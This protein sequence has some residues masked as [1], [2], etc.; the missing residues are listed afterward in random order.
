MIAFK[1]K[2][3]KLMHFYLAHL[4][5][6]MPISDRCQTDQP[7]NTLRGI[8]LSS[9]KVHFSYKGGYKINI[10]HIYWRKHKL[11]FSR[12]K[13]Q[14]TVYIEII[15]RWSLQITMPSKDTGEPQIGFYENNPF[16]N[17]SFFNKGQ[18][19]FIDKCVF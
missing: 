6:T 2:Y 9:R 5:S 13:V 1:L 11:F 3:T 12:K 8:H 19:F 17:N 14:C 18:S 10:D 15:Y 7:L 4:N 16:E